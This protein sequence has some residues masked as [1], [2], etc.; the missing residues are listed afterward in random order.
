MDDN[1]FNAMKNSLSDNMFIEKSEDN[2]ITCNLQ[3]VKNY[4]DWLK[5][6]NWST[7]RNKLWWKPEW[8]AWISA[9]Q[10]LLNEKYSNDNDKLEIDWK[11]WP[12]TKEKVIK[13][14]KEKKIPDDGLPWWDTIKK[15]LDDFKGETPAE[16]PA[17][18][19]AGTP[20][21]TTP[22]PEQTT[23]NPQNLWDTSWME[24][25]QQTGYL[26]TGPDN[27]ARTPT[28]NSDI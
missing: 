24:H 6:D 4:L 21:E 22:N 23:Q 2:K 5:N 12:K 27:T 20:A 17:E 14:Q 26:P 10:I 7:F 9:I 1:D 11:L 15:L 16:S 8:R 28:E 13:F 18:S 25:A 3:K 19:P